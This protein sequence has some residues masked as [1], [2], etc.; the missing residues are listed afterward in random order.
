MRTNHIKA[1]IDKT[2]QKRCT[3]DGDRDEVINY[4]I[5]ECSKLAQ[6]EY[7]TGHDWVGQAYLLG[8]VQ[9]IKV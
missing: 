9:E 6:K 8:I 1:R 3:L 2:L 7:K 4:I 5:S